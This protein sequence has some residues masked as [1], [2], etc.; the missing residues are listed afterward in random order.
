VERLV[1]ALVLLLVPA[2]PL[3]ARAEPGRDFTP[4]IRTLYAAAAC[5]A[6]APSGFDAKVVA[7]HCA[8]VQKIVTRWKT[9]WQTKAAPFFADLLKG[10]YPPAI[11][12]PFGGGDLATM[13]V[14][15][16]DATDYT[17]LSLEG[18]GDPR[19]INELGGDDPKLAGKR[20][21]MLATRLGKLR[22][23]VNETLGWAW[24]TTQDLS[25]SS[26]ETGS[27]LPNILILTLIALDANGYEPL[28]ARFWK[29]DA[30]GAVVYL[31]QRDVDAFD[32]EM[33]GKATKKK[34]NDAVQLGAFNDI[35]IVFRKKGDASAP[36]KTFRHITGDLSDKGLDADR[37]PLAYLEAKKDI[38]AMTK[39]ASYLL[40]KD[41][42]GK[43][44]EYLLQH[45][46][47]MLSDDTGIPPRFAKPAGFSQETW[48]TYGGT[49][50]RFPRQDVAKEM[51][52][53]W[54]LTKRPMPFR[55]GYYDNRRTSHLLYTYR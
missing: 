53:L 15:Y 43:L 50:F 52:E 45:M 30:K 39:A 40:W 22:K 12:Y 8:E 24:N 23:Q 26:S 4:E 17:T 19:T 46:K 54:K 31:A 29:P 2:V 11:V 5:G 55:F 35:E 36:K 21:G 41:T 25:A 37:T 10:Q 7:G 6:P 13:L 3:R 1:V 42:F 9:E 20:A 47:R 18:M 33:K 44:R 28:E 27:G 32:A 49:F 48:G 38:A 34:A 51:V 16:P 14:V